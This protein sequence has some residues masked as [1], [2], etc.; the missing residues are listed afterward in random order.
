[1]QCA[2]NFGFAVGSSKS[3]V[4]PRSSK[5]LQEKG[6][7]ENPCRRQRPCSSAPPTPTRSELRATESVEGGGLKQ[8]GGQG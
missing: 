1:M 8:V 5:G 4:G 6:A 7:H 2:A 3:R